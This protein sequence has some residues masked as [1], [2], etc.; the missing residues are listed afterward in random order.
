MTERVL[1]TGVTGFLGKVILEELVRRRDELDVCEIVVVIR[2]RGETGGQERFDDNVAPS[3]CFSRLP[4]GWTD[5]VTVVEAGLEDMAQLDAVAPRL[6]G[7]TRIVHSAASISFDLPIQ[8]A[9]KSNVD[10]AVNVLELAKR[11]PKLERMVAVSTAY[12]NAHDAHDGPVPEALAP[13]PAPAEELLA[14]IRAG[15]DEADLLR[16]AGLPNTYTYTKCLSE[17]MLAA[18]RGDVPL[19]ILRPSIISCSLH[20]PFPGWIDST[21]GFGGFVAM[22]GLGHLRAVVG[23]RDSQL[24]LVPVDEVVYRTLGGA[25]DDTDGLVIRHA[26]ASA[27]H[28]PNLQDCWDAI[29]DYYAANRVH[30]RPVLS[31]MGPRRL[32]FHVADMLHHRLPV[33]MASMSKQRKRAFSLHRRLAHLNSV[34]PYFTSNSFDFECSQPLPDDFDPRAYLD[35]ACAGI[36]EHILRQDRSQWILAGAQQVG[37]A[38]LAWALDKPYGNGWIRWAAWRARKTM[39][40]TFDQVT[41]DIP[42]FERA[43]AQVP[44]GTPIVLVAS[45]RS[46]FDFVLLSY[47]AFAR[48]DLRIPIPHI[49]ATAD[50]AKIP[51]LG[52]ILQSM[53]AF[54]IRRGLGREDP[55]LTARIQKFLDD[56]KTLEFFIEGTRS[57]DRRFLAPKRGLLRAI[58]SAGRPV[59]V[60]PVSLS[61]DRVPEEPAFAKELAGLDKPK[62]RLRVLLKW[63]RSARRGKVALGR[64]HI[65]C[66][67]PVFMGPEADVPAVADDVVDGLKGAMVTTTFHIDAY[68]QKHPLAEAAALRT[69]IEAGG[70]R[71]LESALPVP[72]LDD[73][74]AETFW[75]QFAHHLGPEPRL[76]REQREAVVLAAVNA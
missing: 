63:L 41:V 65:A 42:S 6:Q 32:R 75:N 60:L 69:A 23:H 76:D 22:L 30:R 34:F 4:P 44:E 20:H 51:L 53:H 70:G 67:E 21:A 62:M 61:Y 17:H 66:A 47:L 37:R 49:A 3:P 7:V 25:F 1:V 14:A 2:P 39:R 33:A 59:A 15:A 12:V 28:S 24:D 13:L 74:I 29:S 5:M 35:L 52:R 45:H 55:E 27:Q 9:A 64:A 36:H 73:V 8:E 40:R 72:E 58:Q 50:F 38:D 56:G 46:Y 48:P 26:A 18:H 19:T 54:Y 31:Y 16:D 43:R 11:L 10:T 57:R 68:L 71:V